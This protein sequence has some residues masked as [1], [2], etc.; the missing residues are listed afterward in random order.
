VAID[1]PS[2]VVGA[3]TTARPACCTDVL[4]CPQLPLLHALIDASTDVLQLH[5]CQ[6]SIV[7][8]QE[9]LGP[10]LKKPKASNHDPSNPLTAAYGPTFSTLP[11]L[12]LL[13]VLFSIKDLIS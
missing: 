9:I 13:H 2:S 1:V 4:Q 7:I 12:A 6:V 3:S 10:L 5:L 11:L 8:A